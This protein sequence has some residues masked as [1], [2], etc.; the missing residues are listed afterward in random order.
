MRCKMKRCRHLTLLLHLFFSLCKQLFLPAVLYDGRETQQYLY[1]SLSC[2]SLNQ[3]LNISDSIQEHSLL[4]GTPFTP[5]VNEMS[6][7]VKPSPAARFWASKFHVGTVV[8][9][10]NWDTWQVNGLIVS[11]LNMKGPSSNDSIGKMGWQS[12]AIYTMY[13]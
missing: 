12:R 11:W 9:R 13:V 3:Y 4:K 10:P 8:E 5:G 1:C 7:R 2:H 6:H